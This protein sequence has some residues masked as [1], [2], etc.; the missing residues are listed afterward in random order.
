M[1][2]HPSTCHFIKNEIV[3]G[4]VMST[5]EPVPFTCSDDFYHIV[6]AQL[7]RLDVNTMDYTPIGPDYSEVYDVTNS[8]GYNSEDDLLYGWFR[9][10]NGNFRLVQIDVNG[11]F[12]QLGNVSGVPQSFQSS[13]V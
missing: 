6:G 1:N 12:R 3:N 5:D 8:L 13:G 2:D 7:N 4:H 9:R 11:V 10:T